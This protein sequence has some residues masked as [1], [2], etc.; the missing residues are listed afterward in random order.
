MYIMPIYYTLHTLIYKYNDLIPL[1]KSNEDR[2]CL[3]ILG[4][5]VAWTII[6]IALNSIQNHPLWNSLRSSFIAI[7]TA[8]ISVML[9]IWNKS[10]IDRGKLQRKVKV[11]NQN[12]IPINHTETALNKYYDSIQAEL[13]VRSRSNEGLQAKAEQEE[14]LKKMD[15]V[16]KIQKYWRSK[17]GDKGEE[18]HSILSTNAL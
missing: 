6:W 3:M 7:L 2:H 16:L 18:F 4:G 1:P 12:I 14:I 8:D 13:D 11:Q 9:Y 10:K 5:T 15:A 17:R